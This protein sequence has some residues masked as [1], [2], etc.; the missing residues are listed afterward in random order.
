MQTRL[1]RCRWW[2]NNV[3]KKK[4]P[5]NPQTV[6]LEEEMEMH[7]QNTERLKS[8]DWNDAAPRLVLFARYWAETHYLWQAGTSLPGGG[9]PEDVA[10]EAIKAFAAG[11]R[12]LNANYEVFTQLKGAI[13]SILWNLHKKID[14]TLTDAHEPEYF[15]NHLDRKPDPASEADSADY[16][17]ILLERLKDEP[18]VRGNHALALVVGAYADGAESVDDVSAQTK[19]SITRIYEL[20]RQL[21]QVTEDVIHKLEIVP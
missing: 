5:K 17:R 16:Y 3:R 18:R 9:T 7:S 11:D 21:K 12:K 10:K 2:G 1:C 8:V 14:L 4:I 13:R 20:R 6:S 15:E 19:L